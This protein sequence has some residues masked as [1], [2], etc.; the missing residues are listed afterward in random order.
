MPPDRTTQTHQP[1]ERFLTHT[2]TISI[3]VEGLNSLFMAVPY[4]R[5]GDTA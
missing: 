2:I 3:L 4:L 5:Q 1:M